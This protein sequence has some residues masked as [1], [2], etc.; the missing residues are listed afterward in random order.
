MKSVIGTLCVAALLA[1]PIP[2]RAASAQAP[3][4]TTAPAD[5]N[6]DNR[7]EK[8]FHNDARLKRYDIKVSVD[9]GV[10]TLSG[11]VPTDADRAK[12]A[13][14]AKVPGISRVDNQLI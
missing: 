4:A 11:T 10:A 9:H 13:E 7:I 2:T 3:A 5:R 14:M 12:A 1:S 6:L 8:K